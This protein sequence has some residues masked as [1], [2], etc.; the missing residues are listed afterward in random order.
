MRTH[1]EIRDELQ[2]MKPSLRGRYGVTE[3][4]VFGSYVREEQDEDSDIDI[5]V[6]FEDPIG[7]IDFLRLE[8]ELA[9]HFEADVDLV[10]KKSLRP[11]VEPRVL[12]EV[13]YA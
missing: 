11:Q 8:N 7:L 12:N 5:V 9:D 13:E 3:I 1:D 4:G 10:T 2:E 6:E